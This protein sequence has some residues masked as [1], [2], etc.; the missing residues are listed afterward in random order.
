M[1]GE[2]STTSRTSSSVASVIRETVPRRRLSPIAGDVDEGKRDVHHALEIADG[3]VLVGRV[4]R[5]HPV[6]D[7]D[8]RAAAL[9]EDVGVGAAAAEA[10]PRLEALSLERGARELH[11]QIAPLEAIARVALVD[12]RL[13]LALLERRSEGDRLEQLLYELRELRLVVGADVDR[14]GAAVG[15][16]V[17]RRPALDQP[18]TRGRLVIQAAE[19][20]VAD[21]A[22]SRH[23]P[24]SR[25][26]SPRS[27]VRA[28][29]PA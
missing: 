17:P 13:G 7:V 11:R 20:E 4:D 15:N 6:R 1:H 5:G 24:P 19:A 10:E 12:R 2:A 3:D 9:V 27:P 18:D 23:V 28:A 22:Q 14:E 25:A 26:S 8:A 29:R 16:D 21:R